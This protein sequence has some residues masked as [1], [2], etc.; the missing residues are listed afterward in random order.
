MLGNKYEEKYLMKDFGDQAG[1]LNFLLFHACKQNTNDFIELLI[2]E[3]SAAFIGL[4]TSQ[5]RAVQKRRGNCCARRESVIAVQI[6]PGQHQKQK[7]QQQNNNKKS[8]SEQIA[9]IRVK[10]IAWSRSKCQQ[11]TRC[12]LA[13]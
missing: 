8:L 9:A 13:I 3:R 10:A 1:S 11:Q 5:P 12:S 6:I 7:Q 4:I 2:V